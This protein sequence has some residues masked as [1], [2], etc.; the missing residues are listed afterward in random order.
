MFWHADGMYE[1]P[2]DLERLQHLLDDSYAAAGPHLRSII[3]AGRR[4]DAAGV[5][6]EMGAMRVMAL[7]TT[8]GQR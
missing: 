4:L 8:D 3:T 7:A 1:S 2:E 5:V 6:T